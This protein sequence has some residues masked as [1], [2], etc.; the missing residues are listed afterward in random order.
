MKS[1]T[2][3]SK[4]SE[5]MVMEWGVYMSGVRV[6]EGRIMKR[7]SRTSSGREGERKRREGE[8]EKV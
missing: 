5:E 6:V 2:A 3:I 7:R 8:R 4:Q 1:S